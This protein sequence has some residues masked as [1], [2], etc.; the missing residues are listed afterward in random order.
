MLC[1]GFTVGVQCGCKIVP[2]EAWRACAP[3]LTER[4]FCFDV[5]LTWHLLHHGTSIR[6]VP[7]NWTEIR[8]GQLH[9]GSVLAMVLSLV[10]LRRQLGPWQVPGQPVP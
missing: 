4:R 5:D 9:A 7:V 8:G 3:A 2:A 6:A 1:C 10:R